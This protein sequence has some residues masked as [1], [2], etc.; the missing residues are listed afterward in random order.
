MFVNNTKTTPQVLKIAISFSTEKEFIIINKIICLFK[1][2]KINATFEAVDIAGNN[3]KKAINY[4]IDEQNLSN[5]KRNDI[6][7]TTCF[8]YNYFDPDSQ[9]AVDTYLDIAMENCFKANF[10]KNKYNLLETDYFIN[11]KKYIKNTKTI[12]KSAHKIYDNYQNND[13]I[14]C[15]ENCDTKKTKKN[16]V[17]NKQ[18]RI[19]PVDLTTKKKDNT[20]FNT[21]FIVSFGHKY[22]IFELKKYN[23]K[24]II[25]FVSKIFEYLQLYKQA[26]FVRNFVSIDDAIILIKKDT[27]NCHH[28]I[29]VD[30]NKIVRQIDEIKWINRD[31]YSIP[32]K[33][34]DLK[35]Q[36]HGIFKIEEIVTAIKQKQVKLPDN[37]ELYQIFIDN[38]EIYPNI[39]FYNKI[40]VN[41]VV[42]LKEKE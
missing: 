37:L 4:G 27:I 20:T 26:S 31:C 16:E 33:I 35:T 3:Y 8:N 29:E 19:R 41:P 9:I 25:N 14:Y 6:L 5:L 12:Q 22:A 24:T 36:L 23:N 32:N 30:I 10:I 18:W 28:C 38:I 39:N 1:W 13:K 7:I 42:F 17:E 2:L 11:N 40:V 21:D 15:D 34:M